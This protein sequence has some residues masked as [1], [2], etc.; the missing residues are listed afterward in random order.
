MPTR[1]KKPSPVKKAR[2]TGPGAPGAQRGKI[3]MSPR[4]VAARLRR[5]QSTTNASSSS[6]K[7]GL[8]RY[9]DK[10][11]GGFIGQAVSSFFDIGNFFKNQ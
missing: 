10:G 6:G 2:K 5:G 7:S 3:G 9:P 4:R 1:Y 8:K 11:P